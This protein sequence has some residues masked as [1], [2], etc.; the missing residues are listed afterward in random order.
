MKTNKI[1]QNI[2]K[3]LI[4]ILVIICILMI[5]IVISIIIK[6]NKNKGKVPDIIG[7][8]PMIVLSGTMET[9]IYTGD[10]AIVK[11]I[12]VKELKQGDIIAFKNSENIILT[13]RIVKIEENNGDLEFITK[14]DNNDSNDDETIKENQIEGK[15]IFKIPG[16]GNFMMYLQKPQ[17]LLMIIIIILL[18]GMIWIYV[19]DKKERNK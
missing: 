2:K 13:H 6:S 15:Y 12:N 11:E 5:T 19:G 10:M 18:F 16:L 8:K 14:G 7:I 1:L 9:E 17:A 3:I 4:A